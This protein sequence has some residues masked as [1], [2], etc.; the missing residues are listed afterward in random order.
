MNFFC[1]F[2]LTWRQKYFVVFV[3]PPHFILPLA[4]VFSCS[5]VSDLMPHFILVIFAVIVCV[6]LCFV[7]C[8][9]IFFVTPAI[10]HLSVTLSSRIDPALF[11]LLFFFNLRPRSSSSPSSFS[12]TTVCVVPSSSSCLSW[13]IHL[14]THPGT[15]NKKL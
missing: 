4:G 8:F 5:F 3:L 13:G 15:E 1:C 12:K 10:S 6:L 11:L 9:F 14:W 7:V 2:N